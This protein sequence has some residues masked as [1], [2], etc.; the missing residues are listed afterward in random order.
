MDKTMRTTIRTLPL[1]LAGLLL[2]LR[3]QPAGAQT[4]REANDSLSARALDRAE[5]RANPETALLSDAASY[6][7][8]AIVDV[9]GGR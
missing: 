9:S 2:A 8:G 7:T 6:A 3:G 1:A 4:L 5:L